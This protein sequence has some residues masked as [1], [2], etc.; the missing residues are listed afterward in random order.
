[1]EPFQLENSKWLEE[2]A[3]AA[4]AKICYANILRFSLVRL[5]SMTVFILS[6]LINQVPPIG[7]DKSKNMQMFT[8]C[9][10]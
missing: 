2:K 8:Q 1:M 7:Q 5:S 10:R 9:V 4:S 6:S 3:M